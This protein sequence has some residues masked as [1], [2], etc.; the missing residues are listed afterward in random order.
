[1]IIL[2]KFQLL[3]IIRKWEILNRLFFRQMKAINKIQMIFTRNLK[4]LLL[5]QKQIKKYKIN[6]S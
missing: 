2:V 4:N 1:M 6:K 3:K 5:I